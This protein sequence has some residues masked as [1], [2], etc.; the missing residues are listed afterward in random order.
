MHFILRTFIKITYISVVAAYCTLIFEMPLRRRRGVHIFGHAI[1]CSPI[2]LTQME[3]Q[4][5]LYIL[6]EAAKGSR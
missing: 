1:P 3:G 5:A 2:Y 4:L 6:R